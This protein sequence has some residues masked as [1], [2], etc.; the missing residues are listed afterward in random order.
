MEPGGWTEMVCIE[1]ANALEN[2]I[3]IEP[4]ASHTMSTT[5]SVQNL[6]VS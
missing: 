5:I 3:V 2:A 1:A 6:P 4:G